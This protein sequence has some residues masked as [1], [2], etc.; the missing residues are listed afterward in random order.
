MS[1]TT[2]APRPAS[3]VQAPP[4]R[5]AAPPPP[6]AMVIFGASGDLTRRLLVPALYNLART[7]LI[8]DHFAIVGVDITDRTAEDWRASLHSMLQSFVGNPSSENRIDA[9]DET[10]W[11]RLTTGISYVQ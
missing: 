1:T 9:I 10:V 4:R 3:V 6:C 11:Q 7:N 5:Q 2:A 8:P